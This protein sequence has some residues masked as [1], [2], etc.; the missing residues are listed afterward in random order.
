MNAILQSSLFISCFIIII[1]SLTLQRSLSLLLYFFPFSKGVEG[2]EGAAFLP[3]PPPGVE[4][5]LL[6]SLGSSSVE[7]SLPLL[8]LP[9]AGEG[10]GVETSAF[11]GDFD[12]LGLEH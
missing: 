12:S 10:L 7:G 8:P 6:D 3:R 1:Q 2:V 9:R 11:A 4:E 5:G